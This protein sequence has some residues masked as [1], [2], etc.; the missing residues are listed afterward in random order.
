MLT[1]PLP[2]PAVP[3]PGNQ[4]YWRNLAELA[5]QPDFEVLVRREFPRQAAALG[6]ALNRR[7]FLKLMGAALALAGLQACT[8]APAEKIVP[9]V[10]QPEQLIPGRPLFFATSMILGGYARWLLAESHE[11][12]PTKV[13]GN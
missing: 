8:P 5:G 9:Y 13:E 4:R 11:G 6:A 10:R 7:D 2:S 3:K 12:R 1:D